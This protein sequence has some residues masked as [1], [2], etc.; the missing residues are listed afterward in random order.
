M[1]LNGENYIDFFH[2][3][4]NGRKRKNTIVSQEKDGEI[5]EGEENILKHAT[6]Y[7]TELFGPVP[8]NNIKLDPTIWDNVEN[9]S[10]L[11]NIVLCQ[12]F[13]EEEIKMALFQMETNKA[14]GPN[15][16]PIEFY[17]GW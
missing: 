14:L 9:V 12:P 13:S 15:I 6:E 4:D 10:K 16:I 11:D 2:K 5:I 3:C 8:S 7:Y 17:Q 1:A